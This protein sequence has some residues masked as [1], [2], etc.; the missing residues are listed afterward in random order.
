MT[1]RSR[2]YV[3]VAKGLA[4]FALTGWTNYAGL[5]TDSIDVLAE[6]IKDKLGDEITFHEARKIAL[7]H[8][9]IIDAFA[10]N[11][12]RFHREEGVNNR[13]AAIYLGTRRKS[14]Q[15]L[16]AFEQQE[17]DQFIEGEF[18]AA[19]SALSD[20][21]SKVSFTAQELID[22]RLDPLK[23]EFRIRHSN[24][25]GMQDLSEAGRQLYQQ[26][27]KDCCQLL[28][29][30]A[31]KMP[32]F[33][34]ASI[35]SILSGQDNIAEKIEILSREISSIVSSERGAIDQN[36]ADFT[37]R[38]K[39]FLSQQLS[40]I[41]QF[42]VSK[43]GEAS[44]DY[45]LS[46]AFVELDTLVLDKS[47]A[48][49]RSEITAALAIAKRFF[50][51]G[52]A[53]TGKTTVLQWIA[54]M[55][56]ACR[57]TEV[58]DDYNSKIPVFI[59]LRSVEIGKLT[60]S[61]LLD[62]IAPALTAS[63]PPGWIGQ[64]L[65][66]GRFLFLLDGLDEVASEHRRDVRAWLE[67]MILEFPDQY[68]FITSR[69]SAVP[70]HWL[71]A[72][73]FTVMNVPPMSGPK[74]EMFIERWH[75]AIAKSA[76]LKLSADDLD[77]CRNR[78][79]TAVRSGNEIRSVSAYPLLASI[80]CTM[81]LQL[82][83][84][85]PRNRMEFYSNA[86]E[87]LLDKRD[88]AAKVKTGTALT[89]TLAERRQYM[90]EL[91]YWLVQNR[92]SG[93]DSNG[94]KRS[95]ERTG[96]NLRNSEADPDA[97]YDFLLERSGLLRE[98]SAGSVEFIHK[99][100]QEYLA[101]SAFVA[102]DMHQALVNQAHLDEFRETFIMAV[103]HSVG[104]RR[105]ILV[106]MLVRRFAAED[107]GKVKRDLGLVLAASLEVCDVLD[108]AMR[109]K[110]LEAV[111]EIAPPTDIFEAVY[112][113][114]AVEADRDLFDGIGLHSLQS[115][116]STVAALSLTGRPDVMNNLASFCDRNEAEVITALLSGSEYFNASE[117]AN[118]IFPKLQFNG[119][120]IVQEK[121]VRF[122]DDNGVDVTVQLHPLVN[123][124]IFRGMKGIK[125]L[126]VLSHSRLH[127]VAAILECAHL[128][129]VR[130]GLVPENLRVEALLEH[131]SLETLVLGER[132]VLDASRMREISRPATASNLTVIS[133]RA[134]EPGPV[135]L[136][137][138][139]FETALQRRID[140][141]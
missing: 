70:A 132:V 103:G 9:T 16:T 50:I 85:L 2:L 8:E 119:E 38:V 35:R 66:E 23:I 106:E 140:D 98:P 120:A 69:P 22:I 15:E 121:Q 122:W 73:A 31:S 65:N 116:V 135:K 44:Q 1:D 58:L 72:L 133:P 86:I 37:S 92:L 13:L 43:E 6:H 49:T 24:R 76:S 114:H 25:Q 108:P 77:K 129:E 68:F 118:T 14:R 100:F 90:Q 94:A 61:S 82:E 55:S 113:S 84:A 125:R 97:V 88:K 104:V 91:A 52:E 107:E 131:H 123:L 4:K 141:V 126:T 30:F 34:I 47:G 48:Q 136:A 39:F 46:T 71:E 63:A 3:L 75:D 32:E 36:M 19:L 56:A 59:R 33:N 62:F 109:D 128:A 124:E 115:V 79:L 101:A 11:L 10:T 87:T 117:Y 112:F 78:V 53:G 7:Q 21:L 17:L 111:R 57:L 74:I 93:T 80:L 54:Q 139:R 67:T 134:I 51:R 99:S 27:L 130:L 60:S 18:N 137:N 110:V 29:G 41:E 40:K 81:S 102:H 28:I 64:C 95:F 83:G 105:D 12:A 138:L 127:D 45:D 20:S 26:S 89:L 5:A 42:G 96:K